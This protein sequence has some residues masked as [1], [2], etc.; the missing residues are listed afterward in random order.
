MMD[1]SD[2]TI[3]SWYL[4]FLK[5]GWDSKFFKKR[6]ET[7]ENLR[8]GKDYF[9]NG[10]D[11]S[12]WLNEDLTLLTRVELEKIIRKRNE[13]QIFRGSLILQEY[14]QLFKIASEEVKLA[15]SSELTS[16]YEEFRAKLF[17][18]MKTEA[19]KKYRKNISEKRSLILE[20]DTKERENLLNNA[21]VE[22]IISEPQ[23]A[24]ERELLIENLEAF[25]DKLVSIL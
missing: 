5:A 6:A 8:A 25:T 4:K 9:G 16:Q 15:I 1:I 12:H 21:I 22:K 2:L 13:E 10:I 3:Q 24:K 7:I 20:M 19:L 23:N 14:S 18:M 11:I 17:G